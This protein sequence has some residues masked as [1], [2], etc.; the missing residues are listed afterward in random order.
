MVLDSCLREYTCVILVVKVSGLQG[1]LSNSQSFCAVY[2]R[3]VRKHSPK[4]PLLGSV[5][6]ELGGSRTSKFLIQE[7]AGS[8]FDIFSEIPRIYPSVP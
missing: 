2:L 6:Q 4:H 1:F 3:C 8:N 5:I 7:T